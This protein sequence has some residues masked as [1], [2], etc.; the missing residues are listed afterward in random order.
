MQEN[1]LMGFNFQSFGILYSDITGFITLIR[2]IY[3]STERSTK[4][5]LIHELKSDKEL[6]SVYINQNNGKQIF[7][8]DYTRVIDH[9]LATAK[10][11][12]EV[13]FDV[14]FAPKGMFGRGQKRFDI[15]A[16]KNDSS[17]IKAD[18]KANFE[19]TPNAIFK[20]IESG[21]KQAEHLVL[22]VNSTINSDDL[23]DG[24]R[25]GLSAGKNVKTI[26]LFYKKRFH[27]LD[28]NAIFSKNIYKMLK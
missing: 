14:I 13:N 6:I 11:I 2:S 18:L 3:E 17:I 5:K 24:L 12:T 16:I 27:N 21:N 8:H 22:D 4:Q 10:K 25:S 28:R 19:P 15:F 9:E 20:L 26:M 7:K 23:I 1:T